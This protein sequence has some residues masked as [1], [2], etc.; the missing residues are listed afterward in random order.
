MGNSE[1]DQGWD[2]KDRYALLKGTP[3]EKVLA[4]LNLMKTDDGHFK[5]GVS[6]LLC[7]LSLTILHHNHISPIRTTLTNSG[8][9]G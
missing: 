6:A 7:L 9:D 2:T 8:L 5:A 1:K 4:W 3:E